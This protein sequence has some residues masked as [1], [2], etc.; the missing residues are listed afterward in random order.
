M[1]LALCLCVSSTL[2]DAAPPSAPRLSTDTISSA[3][4]AIG[5]EWTPSE[6]ALMQPSVIENLAAFERLQRIPIDNALPPALVFTP[7]LPGF[8]VRPSRIQKAEIPLPEAT[9]P[10]DLE[11]LAY[12]DIPTLASLIRS[13]AVSSTEL[14]QMYLARLKRL[15]SQ[16]LCVVHLTEAR[17][18]AQAQQRDREIAEGRWR[19][20][21]H[22]IPWG[23]KDLL[24]VRGTPTTWGS[25]I[26]E[27][28]AID[29]DATVVERLDEAGAVLIAKLSLGEIAYGDLWYRG[30]TR[31]PWKPS[32]GSSGSS[33]G[34][35][36]A[37]AAGCVAFAIGSETLGSI[38]SPSSACGATGLRPTFGRVSRHGA[39]ALS[40][41]MDKIGP[42]CR[43]AQDAAIVFAAIHGP[44]GKDGSVHAFPFD[45]PEGVDVRGW[46]VGYLKAAFDNSPADQ[47][48]LKE[49]ETLGVE[50]VP[51]ELPSA[52]A[53]GD[54]LTI[55]TSEAAAAFDE[56]TRTGADDQMVWQAEEAWPNTFRATRLV[57]AV[58]YIRANRL[59][60][61]LMQSMAGVMKT[62]DLYVHPS[63]GGGS[64][65]ITNLTGHPTV[66][67]PSGFREDGTPTSISFTGGL[68]Q[69]GELLAL[70]QAWQRAS[71][72]HLRHP[73]F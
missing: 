11:E 22:G 9:R 32:E 24:A 49:L 35:A 40:W 48:V 26:Y 12:A 72:Y 68:F 37:T 55:L 45:V 67:A 41:S 59:R 44:D 5:L 13:R 53:A 61:Q 38:V 2:Q 33:A 47:H 8:E 54:L 1:L 43:S 65:T 18:L 21:L 50:L 3:A 10:A 14:V 15:D 17:A 16:L 57:P 60:T 19:G 52:F 25:K 31:N 64:L 62:V 39:M 71:G 23:A 20:L 46:K 4:R 73:R 27:K 51:I 70:A 69:E 56:F 30:R 58:E 66:V 6:L 34:A 63:F 42:L 28:R 36:S 7:L 29:V